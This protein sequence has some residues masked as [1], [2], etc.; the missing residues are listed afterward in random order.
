M[1]DYQRGTIYFGHCGEINTE[2]LLKAAKN[3]TTELNLKKV[4]IASETGRS[5]LKALDVF[6]GSGV[7]MIVVTHCP[8]TTWGP[9]G[10]I[11]IGLMR[12]EYS[13]TLEILR[14]NNVHVVQ[15]TRPFAPPSRSLGW[16]N[17]TPEAM[18]DKTLELFGA[19][20]K[21]A[22]E[23]SVMATDAGE[24]TEGEAVISCGGTFKGLDTALVVRPTYAMNFLTKFEVVEIVAKPQCRVTKLPEHEFKGWK[25]NLDPYYQ[26]QS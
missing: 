17:P 26:N 2:A 12:K 3:R 20:T 13:G 18:I 25:G 15:G 6:K 16:A 1:A 10:D 24:V 23:V 4:I 8:A 19:G 21:I 14:K 7:E 11:L 22:V 5:A 9:K